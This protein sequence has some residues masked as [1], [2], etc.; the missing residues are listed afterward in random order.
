ML[1]NCLLFIYLSARLLCKAKIDTLGDGDG[2]ISP[3]TAVP[4]L[5]LTV[6]PLSVHFQLTHSCAGAKV[7]V[8]LICDIYVLPPCQTPI[9]M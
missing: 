2:D 5:L 8:A 3:R 7:K 1:Y 6:L 9:G 4:I